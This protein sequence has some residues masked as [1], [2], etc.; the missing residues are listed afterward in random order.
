MD[1]DCH[2]KIVSVK[3]TDNGLAYNEGEKVALCIMEEGEISWSN[4]E[5]H[6]AMHGYA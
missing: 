4:V 3:Q 5:T 1:R 6:Q 2:I